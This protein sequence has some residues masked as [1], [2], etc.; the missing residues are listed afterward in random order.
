MIQGEG[1]EFA[2]AEEENTVGDFF[3][4][5]GERHQTGFGFGVGGGFAFFEPAGVIGDEAGGLVDVAR[6]KT[7]QAGAQVGLGDGGEF[8]PSRKAVFG[9]NIRF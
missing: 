4:D 3:A 9:E 7:E 1:F 8:G 6:T 2:R 5:A